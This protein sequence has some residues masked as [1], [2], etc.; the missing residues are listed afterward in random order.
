MDGKEDHKNVSLENHVVFVAAVVCL[1]IVSLFFFFH[2]T[3]QSLD[4]RDSRA[5]PV[6]LMLPDL[7]CRM[8]L[9]R[10]WLVFGCI[11]SWPL[12][13]VLHMI[14]FMMACNSKQNVISR[15][16]DHL[17]NLNETSSYMGLTHT[18]V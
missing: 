16:Q 1:L 4:C 12:W 14:T 13:R 18:F 5:I 6:F 10:C 9:R 15:L 3:I 8:T 11:Q 7:R 17:E 2:D